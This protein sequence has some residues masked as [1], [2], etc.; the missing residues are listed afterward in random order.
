MLRQR[1][2]YVELCA[3]AGRAVGLNGTFQLLGN[4][5]KEY[6][7]AQPAAA[8]ATLGGKEGREYFVLVLC[9]Y[10]LAVV[11]VV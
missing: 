5:V 6:V 11:L 4:Q 2:L 8:F 9:G 10:A 1:K 7:Q 3:L